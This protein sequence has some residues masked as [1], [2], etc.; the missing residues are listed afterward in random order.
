MEHHQKV[1]YWSC[2]NHAKLLQ[3]PKHNPQVLLTIDLAG[4]SS[5]SNDS[6]EGPWTAML[7]LCTT[8]ALRLFRAAHEVNVTLLR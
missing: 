2:H 4:E 1:Q 7:V 6:N 3:T 8:L 5:R